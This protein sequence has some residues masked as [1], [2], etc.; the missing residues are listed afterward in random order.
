MKRLLPA[1]TKPYAFAAAQA[2]ITTG[3]STFI[4]SGA[5]HLSSVALW[6]RSWLLSWAVL[7]PLV[8]LLAPVIWRL[9]GFVC[10]PES[11]N[12]AHE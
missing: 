3:V 8:V 6:L 10:K 9:L 12:G 1:R 7:V 4:A 5:V 2:L 11:S